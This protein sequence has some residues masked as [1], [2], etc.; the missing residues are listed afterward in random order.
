MMT[1]DVP[2]L[3]L[4]LKQVGVNVQNNVVMISNI[5]Q[6]VTVLFSNAMLKIIKLVNLLL[7]SVLLGRFLS[8]LCLSLPFVAAVGN[9]V[10]EIKPLLLLQHRIFHMLIL[11]F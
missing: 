4:K 8:V 2:I 3:K 1:M 10:R 11:V 9:S 6:K 7:L 5:L